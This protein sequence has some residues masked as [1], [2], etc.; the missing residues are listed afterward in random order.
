MSEIAIRADG[1]GKRYRIGARERYKT[2]RDSLTEAFTAPFRRRVREAA[3]EAENTFWAVKDVSFDVKRGEVIG[4]IGRNG[5]GKSTL[6]KILSRITEP[7]EGQVR[8]HGRVASLLEVGTGF[9]PEL[10]GRDNIHLNGAILGMKKAEIRRQFD[11]IVDFAEVERFVDTPVKHYSSGMYMRL[12]FAVAA[13]LNPEILLID[14]VLAVGDTAF[15]KKCLA[16]MNDVAQ[17]G[18][19]VLFVSHNLVAVE[20]LCSRAVLL[21]RGRVRSVG[22]ARPVIDRYLEQSDAG[23]TK[24]LAGKRRGGT[25]EIRFTS[26]AVAPLES[27]GAGVVRAG[28]DFE[29]RLEYRSIRRVSRPTFSVSIFSNMSVHVFGI[30]TTDL[31]FEVGDIESDGGIALRI[32]RPNLMPGRYLIHISAGDAVNS[33]RYDHIVDAADLEIEPA[34]VYGSGRV[35]MAN[36]TIL[37]LDCRWR[38]FSPER[39][40][41]DYIMAQPARI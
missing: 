15:Q 19:T 8:I 2:L 22:T 10:T 40:S 33:M 13:H 30:H 6:L 5:A 29:I 1:L 23:G 35:D 3:D 25:G 20:S 37:Y 7:T 38:A 28:Q 21:D 39:A 17:E 14:E 31:N 32:T 34:D 36:W 18:R 16:R 12:A 4:I 24:E 11:A 41:E 26:V 9:H 27:R